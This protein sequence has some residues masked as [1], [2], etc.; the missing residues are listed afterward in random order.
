MCLR[1]GVKR[2]LM[3]LSPPPYSPPPNHYLFGTLSQCQVVAPWY[4][5]RVTIKPRDKS[6]GGE[7]V[8]DGWGISRV[9][10]DGSSEYTHHVPAWGR[11]I[12]S[13]GRFFL[14]LYAA[15]HLISAPVVWF[16]SLIISELDSLHSITIM[17]AAQ[18]DWDNN[19]LS[20]N[21]KSRQQNMTATLRVLE[22]I[23]RVMFYIP[24]LE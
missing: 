11:D 3:L 7:E 5:P 1:V 19:S 20:V 8:M 13:H 12:F 16:I 6:M 21:P 23:M 22:I 24:L 2:L 15:H 17:T 14:H 4:A 9:P 10:H 18:R